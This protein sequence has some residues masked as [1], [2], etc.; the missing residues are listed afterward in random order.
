MNIGF[1]GN[2]FVKPV[3]DLL[4]ENGHY[5]LHNKFSNNL[6][7]VICESH[8]H[9]YNFY[10]FVKRTNWKR[11]KL[12][13]IILDIPPWRL[14]NEFKLNHISY[15]IK[16]HYYH[17]TNKYQF[18]NHYL[19]KLKNN[20]RNNYFTSILSRLIN[21]TPDNFYLNKIFY[22]NNYRNFLKKS[23]LNLS[24]SNFTEECVKKF[25]GIN[26]K[27]WYPAVNSQ[28]LLNIPKSKDILYDCINISR[29]SKN[30]RQEILVKAANN[31]RLKIAVIGRYV[32]KNIKLDCPSYYVEKYRDLMEILNQVRFYVD[33]SEFEGFGLTPVE[34]AFLNKPSIVS[35]T[36]VHREILGDYPLYFETNNVDDLIKKM[37]MILNGEYT[38]NKKSI[39]LI[40]KKYSLNAA[41]NRLMSYIESII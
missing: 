26:S 14:E 37:R 7:I 34:A 17:Y 12:I 28:V 25:L 33:P 8:F 31:L 3:I 36:Y 16:Q 15:Q 22:Q 21:K 38:S 11:I 35:N 41:K 1:F 30:K 18:L 19:Q 20:K 40:K 10:K 29:I 13:N 32:D 9:M 24:I 23:S 27:I 39:E 6:D 2:T 5:I 4:E